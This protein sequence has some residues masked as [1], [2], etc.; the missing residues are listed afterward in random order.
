MNY[1]AAT[2]GHLV[3]LT[4]ALHHLAPAAVEAA[5]VLIM[6]LGFFVI[7]FGA[8]L[9][10]I[11]A[12]VVFSASVGVYAAHRNFGEGAFA[13]VAGMLPVLTTDW[14]PE[15]FSI[16]V[17]AWIALGL[18]GLLVRSL[19]IASKSE[20]PFFHAAAASESYLRDEGPQ[21]VKRVS[22]ELPYSGLGPIEKAE[23]LREFAFRKTSTLTSVTTSSNS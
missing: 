13:L 15:R 5:A 23:V 7:H 21:V 8:P 2:L 6:F 20:K 18:G 11:S 19:A 16:F 12:L 3:S 10:V 14:N 4:K 22:E 1:T 9:E 17:A